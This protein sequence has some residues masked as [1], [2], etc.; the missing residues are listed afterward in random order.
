MNN[1]FDTA[2]YPDQVPDEL[3]VG[4]L[5][6]WTRS[7]ITAAYPT[8]L[9]TLSFRFALLESPYTEETLTA[10]KVDSAH[11][12][13]ESETGSYSAGEYRWYAKVTRDSDSAAV[14]VDEGL[15]TFRPASGD[16]TGHVY[17]TLSAIRAVIEGT[18]SREE[19]AYSINGRSLNL[20]T[21]EELLTL[22]REYGKRWA[23]EK[24]EINRK[25]G[26]AAKSRVLVKMRA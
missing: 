18:A 4:A 24:A 5:F 20:R 16:D 12:I 26:R 15:V 25:A 22:E 10:S 3:T 8:D 11:V 6:S 23:R 9:Y 13:A 2:N 21:P 1:L 17:K 7:D 19:S 14:Q